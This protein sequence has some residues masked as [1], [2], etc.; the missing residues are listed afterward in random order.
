MENPERFKKAM[1]QFDA[2]NANDPHQEEFNGTRYPKELL[3]GRRMSERLVLFAP[4][5]PE[6]LRLAAR[7]QHIGRWEIPRDSYPM[8]RAGYLKWRSTLKVHHTK[9][10]SEILKNCMYDDSVI[11]KVNFLL[12]KK[13]L[14]RNVDTQLLE[15]VICL[16]FIQYYLDE[17]AAKH[18]PEKVVSI[19]AKT[20]KKMSPKAISEV[21][22]IPIS[23]EIKRLIREAA[24][25]DKS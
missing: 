22:K 1:E 20:M 17:F 19:L 13:E 12:L 8:D 3:Y 23:E 9:I 16:V 4:E 25:R 2:Y 10:A 15:D 14:N 5:A 21:A 6:Y 24:E 11:E 18:E 7:C